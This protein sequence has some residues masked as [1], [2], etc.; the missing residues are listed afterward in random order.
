VTEGGGLSDV[1]GE[2]P[3]GLIGKGDN[4]G[5]D[6][7]SRKRSIRRRRGEF[8]HNVAKYGTLVTLVLVIA[9][10]G[11][12][13]PHVFFTTDN[14]RVALSEM[15]PIAIVAFG[16]TVVLTMGDFDLSIVGMIGLSSAVLVSLIANQGFPIVLA[17]LV[18]MVMAAFIGTVQGT[19]VSR[20][21]ASSF[22]TTLAVGQVLAGI[23]L[24][25]TDGQVIFEGVPHAFTQIA[26]GTPIL[27]VQNAVWIMVG[28]FVVGYLLLEHTAIGRYMHAIGSNSEAARMSGL[29]VVGIRVLGYVITAICAMIAALLLSSTA[30]SYSYA[31][32]STYFLPT[33]AA[34]FLGATVLRPGSFSITGTLIGALFLETVSNGLTI[35]SAGPST[36]QIVQGCLLATAVLLSTLSARRSG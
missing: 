17:I 26:T 13:S 3:L 30:G 1:Y 25:I 28:F 22:I 18:T 14:L 10:F 15:A 6:H 8:L 33:Y 21:G 27:G 24:Q 12:L 9:V 32:G 23:N 29:N 11:V 2:K 35:Q 31:I 5:R 20:F 4:A 7:G 34:V 16:L 36:V 19:V